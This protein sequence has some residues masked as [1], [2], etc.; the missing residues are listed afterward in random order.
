MADVKKHFR[1]QLL[2]VY[3]RRKSTNS[4]KAHLYQC[5][6]LLELLIFSCMPILLSVHPSIPSSLLSAFL[7][8]LLPPSHHLLAVCQAAYPLL[9]RAQVTLSS[10][11]FIWIVK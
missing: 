1:N 4:P 10:A 6:W 3:L 11:V 7:P 8:F 2:S 9:W 5:F